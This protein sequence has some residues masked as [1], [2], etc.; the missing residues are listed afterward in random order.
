M[1]GNVKNLNCIIYCRVSTSKQAQQGES[2]D[3]QESICRGIAERSNLNVIQVFKEQYSGRKE[4]RPIIED[5]FSFLKKNPNKISVLIIRSID[6]FTRNGTFGYENLNQRLL[7]HG[8]QLIDSNGIIQPYKN[9]L[10]HLD[11]SYIW[12]TQRPSEITELVMAQQGKMEVSQIL[13]RTIGAEIAL[14]RDGYHIGPPREGY[15]NGKMEVDGKKKP[16]QKAHMIR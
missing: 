11:V 3:L 15:I 13:I 4:E 12:A 16:I 6:R 8:V 2:L 7:G 5:I 1:I 14:V 10:E 9:M